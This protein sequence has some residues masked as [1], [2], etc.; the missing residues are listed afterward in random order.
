[1]FRRLVAGAGLPAIP[2]HGLRHTHASLQIEAGTNLAVLS[3]R[4]GHGGIEVTVN[5][6]GHVSAA[7]DHGA[8]D[9][10]AELIDG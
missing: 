5:V 6:Y 9:K 10:V 1:M 3:R 7:T 4:L 2:L 8:A